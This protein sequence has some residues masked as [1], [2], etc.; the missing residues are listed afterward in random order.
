MAASGVPGSAPQRALHTRPI[1]HFSGR[2]RW[3]PTTAVAA[4]PDRAGPQAGRA[5]G[6]AKR[7]YNAELV[8]DGRA[9][10]GRLRRG[11]S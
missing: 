6:R 1:V 5:A 2:M 11:G 9:G 8:T 10:P 7:T 4:A 3:A